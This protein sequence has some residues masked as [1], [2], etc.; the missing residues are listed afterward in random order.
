ML[1]PLNKKFCSFGFELFLLARVVGAAAHRGLAEHQQRREKKREKRNAF[2]V[3][4][5]TAKKSVYTL[6]HFQVNGLHGIHV[7]HILLGAWILL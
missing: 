6:K 2:I 5:F 3:I 1:L 7:S 4:A